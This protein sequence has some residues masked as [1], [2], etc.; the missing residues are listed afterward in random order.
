M[1]YEDYARGL[2]SADWT[3]PDGQAYLARIKRTLPWD[4]AELVRVERLRL[5]SDPGFPM[6]D[7]SYCHGVMRDGEPCDV[8]LPFDQ[9]PKNK[10]LRRIVEYAKEDGV[11]A[12]GLGILDNI[13]FFC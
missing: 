4:S 6:W 8:Q 10:P 12:R 13:S 7:V 5:I 2:P 3:T 1:I 11:Y 9:L